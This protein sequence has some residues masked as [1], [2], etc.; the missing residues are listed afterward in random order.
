MALSLPSM[1]VADEF[2]E[3]VDSY[4]AH[5]LMPRDPLGDALHF[6]RASIRKCDFLL[7]W[8]CQHLANANKFALVLTSFKF[9][10]S[11]S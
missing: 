2:V 3:I 11:G 8:N 1:P 4:I 7:K 9:L 6:A 5:R 10:T